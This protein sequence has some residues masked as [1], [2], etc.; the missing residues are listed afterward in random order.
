MLYLLSLLVVLGLIVVQSMVLS[1][2]HLFQT[3][4]YKKLYKKELSKKKFKKFNNDV[5][6]VLWS[7]YIWLGF[8]ALC[9]LFSAYSMTNWY[10]MYTGPI[11]SL[12]VGVAVLVATLIPLISSAWLLAGLNDK[13]KFKLSSSNE[14]KANINFFKALLIANIALH[15]AWVLAVVFYAYSGYSGGKGVGMKYMEYTMVEPKGKRGR[16]S[17]SMSDEE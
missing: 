11:M 5:Q 13:R 14:K 16:K 6:F 15:G 3:G 1:N 4:L 10:M 12:L 2:A 7:G 17:H 9:A 8:I